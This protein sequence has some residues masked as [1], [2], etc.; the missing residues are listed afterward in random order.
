M[1]PVG[2]LP[3][4]Q[5][6]LNAYNPVW[7]YFTF[8][9]CEVIGTISREHLT[10][11]LITSTLFCAVA[12]AAVIQHVHPVP[13][14]PW[15]VCL[16]VGLSL[17]LLCPDLSDL[18]IPENTLPPVTFQRHRG[19]VVNYHVTWCERN[20]KRQTDGAATCFHLSDRSVVVDHYHGRWH[21][22]LHQ[23]PAYITSH[24]VASVYDAISH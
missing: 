23:H 15:S 3:R 22:S 13:Q 6:Q 19:I 17:R 14:S 7:D 21:R 5:D 12:D 1:S 20:Q 18:V 10:A 9:Y 11:M 4:N 2:W 24:D 8:F 16:T